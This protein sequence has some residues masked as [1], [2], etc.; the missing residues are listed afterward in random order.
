MGLHTVGDHVHLTFEDNGT[1][2]STAHMNHVF[3]E[4]YTTK[5]AGDGTGLGL[6]IAKGTVEKNGGHID[7]VTEYGHFTVINIDFPSPPAGQA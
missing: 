2:I 5:P 1:G 4:F 3:D 7:L 6:S